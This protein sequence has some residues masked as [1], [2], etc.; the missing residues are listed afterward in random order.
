MN[1]EVE[2]VQRL[3]SVKVS[4]IVVLFWGSLVPLCNV[5]LIR[6]IPKEAATEKEGSRIRE[7]D[8]GWETVVH[9]YIVM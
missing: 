4:N 7:S 1:L 6:S 5:F 8:Q 9:F 3:K 2:N